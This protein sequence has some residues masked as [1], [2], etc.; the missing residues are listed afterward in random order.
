MTPTAIG[1]IQGEHAA[2]RAMLQSM[3]M[4]V[5]RGLGERPG[6]VFDVLRAKQVLDS[7]GWWRRS[8]N[9]SM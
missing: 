8:G 9:S 6:Q 1:I 4:L 3:R 7:F 5:E 2:L